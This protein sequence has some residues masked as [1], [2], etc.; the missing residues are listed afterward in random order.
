LKPTPETKGGNRHAWLLNAVALGLVLFGV[1]HVARV[2]PSRAISNDFAHYYISSRLLLTGR[3]VYTTPLPPEYE[4][5]GFRYTHVIPSATNPPLLVDV[6]ALFAALPPRAAFWAWALLEIVSLG[7]VLALTWRLT[8]TLVSGLT[9]SRLSA[10]VRR[11]VCAGIIASA[12][13]YWHF[14]FSQSQLLIAAVILIA[15]ACLRSGRPVTACLAITTATW[16]KLYPVML[17]PWFLWRASREWKTRWRCAGAALAWSAVVVFASGLGEW[18]QFWAHGMKV[19][20]AWAEWQRH[21]NFTVP[22]FVKN[23]AWLLHGF[24]PEWTGLHS[25]AEAGAIIG[26]ALIAVLYGVSWWTGRGKES[27]DIESEFCLLTIAMLAGIAEGWGHYFVMLAFPV[28]VAVAR[29]VQRPTSG[30]AVA[31]GASLVMLNVMGDLRSPW[32]EFTVSYIPLYG[33]LLLGAFF[34]NEMRRS[35]PK[36]ADPTNPVPQRR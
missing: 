16:L 15:Y 22:S 30:R 6:F 4:R 5:W 35:Q 32:L 9:A 31:L 34:V 29:V 36:T 2:L 21:F 1:A 14:Y 13:V 26:L 23:T 8:P 27:A 25:W 12:P 17:V 24:D 28:A 33:L 20:E 19:L 3:D 10:P 18:R 7:C 11:L